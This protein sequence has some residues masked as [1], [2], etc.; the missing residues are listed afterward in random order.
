VDLIAKA[1][2]NPGTLSFASGGSGTITHLVAEL[3]KSSAG[4]DAVHVRS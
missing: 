4:I 3:F 1:R 2:A